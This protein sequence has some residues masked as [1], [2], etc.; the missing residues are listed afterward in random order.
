MRGHKNYKKIRQIEVGDFNPAKL[1]AFPSSNSN[2]M[3]I[4]NVYLVHS[5]IHKALS[6]GPLQNKTVLHSNFLT[7]PLSQIHKSLCMAEH[8]P[9][10]TRLPQV[11]YHLNKMKRRQS[12]INTLCLICIFTITT[13]QGCLI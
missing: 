7:S 13:Q 8:P 1:F 9:K 11:L 5:L 2:L 4:K 12:M 3:Y 10:M 6:F